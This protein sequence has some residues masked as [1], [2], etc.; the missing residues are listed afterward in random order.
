MPLNPRL[1]Q[2]LDM[3]AR[4]KRLPM[5]EMT[6]L[7]A[8]L[9]YEKSAQILDLDPLPLTHVE[10]LALPYRTRNISAEQIYVC[11]NLPRR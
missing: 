1:A 10:D 4:A 6:P 7:Q 5:H 9:S 8:R 2:L 3:I 11:A